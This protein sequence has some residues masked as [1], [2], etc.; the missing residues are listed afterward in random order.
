MLLAVPS[1]GD[2]PLVTVLLVA[3]RSQ[4]SAA[5]ILSPLFFFPPFAPFS[6]PTI[7]GLS[8]TPTASTCSQEA[9]FYPQ[10]GRRIWSAYASQYI[11]SPLNSVQNNLAQRG[12]HLG[13]ALQHNTAQPG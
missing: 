5:L 12:E 13:S 1:Q 2:T 3:P 11:P 10:K 6:L 4:P 8:H 9:G 7:E